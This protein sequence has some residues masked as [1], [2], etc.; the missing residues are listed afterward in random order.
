MN[1]NITGKSKIYGV[2]GDPIA[3]SMSPLFQNYLLRKKGLDSLYIPIKIPPAKLGAGMD[4]L[5][6]NLAGFN[7][8]IPHKES[9]MPY[10]DQIDPLALEY[11]AVNTV[12][13]VDG[14]LTGYNTDGVG[15]VRSLERYKMDLEGKK[16]LLLGAGGA[17]KVIA[18]EVVKAG[19]LLSIANRNMSRA[20]SIRRDI[21]KH[22]DSRID[23][24]Q[25]ESISPPYDIVINSTSV[26]MEPRSGESI[27][28]GH[29]LEGAGLVYDIVYNPPESRLLKLGKEQGAMTIN[30]LSML[31]YQGLESFEIWTGEKTSRQ[32]YEEIYDL[33]KN[34]AYD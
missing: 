9:I 7:V 14:K 21:L 1:H 16:V 34:F 26:G 30:G 27:V 13:L 11:G 17:A 8:T 3:H 2:L 10:L 12:K 25:L 5:R 31:L 32:D 33:V 29:V 19:G 20:H 22:Y 4:L 24:V 28:D 23:L 15:F 6:E 18:F